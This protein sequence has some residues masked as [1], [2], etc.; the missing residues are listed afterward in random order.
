MV[1]ATATSPSTDPRNAGSTIH[2]STPSPLPASSSALST[3]SSAPLSPLDTALLTRLYKTTSL[4]AL[5]DS[6][7][8]RTITGA[9][10]SLF[11]LTQWANQDHIKPWI[12]IHAAQ[13]REAEQREVI[14]LLKDIAKTSENPVERRRAA[15]SILRALG[16]QRPQRSPSEPRPSGSGT[17]RTSTAQFITGNPFDSP[18]SPAHPLTPSPLHPSTNSPLPAPRG[19]PKLTPSPSL[20]IFEAAKAVGLALLNPENPD[21]LATLQAFLAPGCTI[22]SQPVTTL[23]AQVR[24]LNRR[25]ELRQLIGPYQK[26]DQLY[27]PAADFCTLKAVYTQKP[28]RTCLSFARSPTSPHPNA[29]LLTAIAHDTS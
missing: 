10:T 21:D 9:P 14:A 2:P 27:N 23:P 22:D 7:S 19:T 3:P 17:R 13:I 29:W 12:D 28:H 24:A 16:A 6:L 15:S 5:F 1:A 11:A 20:S 4:P 25:G 18:S 8:Q 26:S